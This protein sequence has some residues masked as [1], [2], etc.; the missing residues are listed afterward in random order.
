[1]SA[2]YRPARSRVSPKEGIWARV[3]VV[4][5]APCYRETTSPGSS[6]RLRARAWGASPSSY[7]PDV[8]S[9]M[10]DWWRSMFL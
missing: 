5:E 6:A 8:F 1:V 2:R 4:G 3:H 9:R 10:E 7:S